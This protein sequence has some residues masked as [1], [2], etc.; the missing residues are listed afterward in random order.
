MAYEKQLFIGKLTGVT[1]AYD[2]V[3]ALT[4][5]TTAGQNTITNIANF[6]ATYDINLLRVGQTINTVTGG[7]F[8]GDVLI[9][10]VNIGTQTVTV[11]TTAAA[12][13]TGGIFT[14]DTP[15][16][17]YFFNSASFSDPQG[18]IN[19]NNV[20]GSD[21]SNY[22]SALTP[23]YA[24]I[25]QAASTLGGSIIN[26]K[27]HLYTISEVTYRDIGT[28]GISAFVKWGE[29]GSESDSGDFLFASS[30]QSLAIGAMSTTSSNV[31]IFGDDVITGTAAGS[32]IAG[33]QIALPEIIDQAQTGSG[34]SGVGFPFSGSAQIT[35]SL[36]LTGSQANLIQSA[37]NFI[38]KNATAPT[39][40]LFEVKGDGVAVF[41]AN[42]S[43]TPPSVVLGGLYF[44]TE[45]A[46]LG[47]N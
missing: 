10:N 5:N 40:S 27:F 33:Y 39:Q 22:N 7:G 11:N 13:Q 30:N 19:V 26:G 31:T 17:T 32:D 41:R 21:D 1:P 12:T 45:S 44:T 16:G 3:V 25:G 34:G 38:I 14:A 23:K 2:N 37:E 8:S 4:G 24:L 9:T 18:V 46:F 20:T 15:A 42:N 47:V 36:G 28:A 35:G 29:Q 43:G 6:N